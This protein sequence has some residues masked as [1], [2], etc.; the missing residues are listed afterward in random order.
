MDNSI[1]FAFR[2]GKVFQVYQ[3]IIEYLYVNGEFRGTYADLTKKFGQKT[4]TCK[5]GKMK[6][7]NESNFRK[8]ILRLQKQD[9]VEIIYVTKFIK[10]IKLTE[11]WM[12][13][14]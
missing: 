7:G 12:E 11:N 8:Y 13:N 3:K 14:I 2:Y 5:N 1:E 6:L 9:I 10:I 4:T